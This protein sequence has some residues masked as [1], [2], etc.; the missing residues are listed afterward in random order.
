MDRREQTDGRL[1]SLREFV[2]IGLL[3]SK[4]ESESVQS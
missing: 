1:V 2:T 4:M 3:D